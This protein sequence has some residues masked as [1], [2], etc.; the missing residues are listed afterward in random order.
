MMVRKKKNKQLKQKSDPTVL[1][2]Q[3]EN[4]YFIVGYTD[5]GFPME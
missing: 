2:A 3:D 4:F 1:F 5:G